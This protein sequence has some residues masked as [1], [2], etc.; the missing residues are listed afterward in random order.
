MFINILLITIFIISISI[1]LFIIF[2]KIP[3]LKKIEPEKIDEYRENKKKKAILE[4]KFTRDVSAFRQKFLILVKPT[5]NLTS[6]FLKKQYSKLYKIEEKYR[7]KLVKI[8]FEDKISNESHTLRHIEKAEKFIQ[9]K[10]WLLAENEYVNAL[11]LD[12]HN[13]EIYKKLADLYIQSKELEKAKETYEYIIKIEEN[14]HDSYNKLGDI[15]KSMGDLNKTIEQYKIAISKSKNN[16]N[17]YYNLATTYLKIEKIEESFENI[18][19]AINTEPENT[20]FL[21]FLINLSIIMGDRE[22]GNK[23]LSKLLDIEPE[24]KKI[25]EFREKLEKM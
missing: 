12:V 9:N 1:V 15:Y 17:Y 24:N 13:I 16:A 3:Q 23:T 19:N 20:V 18:N 4:Q 25:Q 11:K 8:H 2:K 14:D 5:L 22:L 6:N 7:T 21:D 10:K